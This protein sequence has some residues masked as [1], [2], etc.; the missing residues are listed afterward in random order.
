[1]IGQ[2]T[3]K[4]AT[5]IPPQ[6]IIETNGIG[7]EV[8]MPIS[9]CALIKIGESRVIHIHLVVREDGHFLYGFLGTESKK[10]FRELIKISGIGP[11]IALSLLSTLSP[12]ELQYAI[13]KEDVKTLCLTPGIGKKMAERML[14]ELKDKLLT[15]KYSINFITNKKIND[16]DD[17]IPNISYRNDIMNALISLGYNEKESIN[18]IKQLSIEHFADLTLGIKEALKLMHK[19]KNLKI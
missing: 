9:D 13:D 12:E 8:D 17:G 1:M 19:N 3:G 6:I 16:N 2:I 14:L 7:Y 4:I 5:I 11:K 10:C 15:N 18:V